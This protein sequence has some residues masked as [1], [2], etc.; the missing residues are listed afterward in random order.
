MIEYDRIME[1]IRVVISRVVDMS[2]HMDRRNEYLQLFAAAAI[3]AAAKTD[4][5]ELEKY[6]MAL[7]SGVSSGRPK[8]CHSHDVA[9]QVW[10]RDRRSNSRSMP[11]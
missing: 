2:E 10:P 6:L 8:E 9:P 1:R 3:L 4:D 5:P 7:S 11:E